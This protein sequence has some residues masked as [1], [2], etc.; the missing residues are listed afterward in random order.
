MAKKEMRSGIMPTVFAQTM[1]AKRSWDLV[2]GHQSLAKDA[3]FFSA[4]APRDVVQNTGNPD[5]HA[6]TLHGRWLIFRRLIS[7]VEPDVQTL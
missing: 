5:G 2:I 4:F 6:R 7:F 3:Q 1:P